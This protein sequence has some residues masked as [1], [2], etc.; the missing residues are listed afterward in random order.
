MEASIAAFAR[1]QLIEGLHKCSEAQVNLFK[2]MYSFK[3]RDADIDTVV[4]NMPEDKL[5][6]ALQQVNRTLDK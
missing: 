5:D 1:E 2:Q 3:N 4:A 6:W